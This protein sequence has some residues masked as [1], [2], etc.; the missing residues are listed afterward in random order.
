M[1]ALLLIEDGHRVTIF[2]RFDTPSPVGSGLILQ[3]TGLAVFAKL[4]LDRAVTTHGARID[5]L[6]GRAGSDGPVVLDVRYKALAQP[7]TTGI[8]LHRA[9]LFAI[10][11][12]AAQVAG[13]AIE[14]GRTVIG[15]ELISGGLRH[16]IF[17]DG[18]TSGPFDL[19]IDALGT[20]S[21][22]VLATG[23]E[24][25]YGALWANVDWVDNAGFDG[26]ALEQRY[27][28]ASVMAGVLPIGTV[29]GRDARQ[30]ALFWSLRA[31]RLHAWRKAGVDAWKADVGAFWPMLWPLLDQIASCDQLTFAR[32]VHRT[33]PAPAAPGLIHL[34]DSWHSTSP[35]LGQ[36]ANMAM[37]DAWALATSLKIHRTVADAIGWAVWLRR[38]HVGFYQLLSRLFTPVYQSDGSFLPLLRDHLAGPLS[39]T[40]PATRILAAM[41][42]GTLGNPIG[43][44]GL[45]G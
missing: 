15:T 36:G 5:R 29:P 17:A 6:F 43:R 21:P 20:R 26:A 19:V 34:G 8:G 12:D 42:A 25:N 1:A 2:E 22:L 18:G 37:L 27:H 23:R 39:K 41:V 10:L 33:L 45:D 28:R 30:A 31:D 9:R 24:L 16:I 13:I 44:L 32:Y 11:H 40:W 38:G 7:D 14:T 3:P 4:A 35:Q